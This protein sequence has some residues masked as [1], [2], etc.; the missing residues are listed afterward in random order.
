[1]NKKLIAKEL[2]T[3]AKELVST[4]TYSDKYIKDVFKKF[5]HPHKPVNPQMAA[6]VLKEFQEDANEIPIK[7]ELQDKIDVLKNIFTSSIVSE[8]DDYPDVDKIIS[9]AIKIYQK[10]LNEI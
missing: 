7:E 8:P 3:L 2:I 6:K 10:K 5:I 1:M 9:K 4:H